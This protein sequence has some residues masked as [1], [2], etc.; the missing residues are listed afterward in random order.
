MQNRSNGRGRGFT[1]IEM[2]VV[3]VIIAVLAALLVVL[4]KGLIDR[5]RNAS[6]KALVEVLNKGCADYRVQFGGFPATS[7]YSGS[8]NLHYYLGIPR[9]MIKQVDPAGNHITE[10]LPPLVEFRKDWLDPSAA[11]SY[12]NPPVFVFDAYGKVVEY[13]NPGL[14]NTKGVDIK[15]KGRDDADAADDI[16]NYV[17]DF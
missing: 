9:V 13:Y 11:S 7:P 6:C 5:S 15:C 16:T 3:I 14:V 10:T 17:R 8:Q 1:L 12:P 4:I 2:L